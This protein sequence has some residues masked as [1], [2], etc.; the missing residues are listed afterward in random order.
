MR[1][2]IIL[3]NILFA[4]NVVSFAK[5]LRVNNN[6]QGITADFTTL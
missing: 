6:N 4:F 5:I 1:K 2:I 3:T